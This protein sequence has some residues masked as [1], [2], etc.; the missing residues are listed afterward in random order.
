MLK[1]KQ[2]KK[3]TAIIIL[4]GFL[5][6]FS[7]TIVLAFGVAIPYST[8]SPLKIYPGEEKVILLNLQNS[9]SESAITVEGLILSGNE[10]ATLEN[11]PFILEFEKPTNVKMTVAIPESAVIG[12]K[13]SIL[14]EFNQVPVDENI[15]GTG[16]SFSQSVRREFEAQVIERPS[17][18]QPPV[19][20]EPKPKEAD[21]SPF[22]IIL[23]I[24]IL[25]V[26]LAIIIVVARKK[27]SQISPLPKNKK[28][29][30]PAR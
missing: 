11:G 5:F 17:I 9:E 20:P 24:I 23:V 12:Q 19:Q 10:I 3:K 22:I 4:A 16:V 7:S 13:Y 6:F 14:Y 29:K 28:K 27:T 25:I 30:I 26:I 1:K 8:I 21:I 2:L 15:Q 18:T